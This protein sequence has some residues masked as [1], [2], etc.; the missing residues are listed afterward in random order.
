[1]KRVLMKIYL[2]KNLP[3]I[4]MKKGLRKVKVDLLKVRVLLKVK[5]VF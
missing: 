2:K 4:L 1:M 3:Q 5:R